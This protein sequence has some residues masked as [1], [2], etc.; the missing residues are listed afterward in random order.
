MVESDEGRKMSRR[1]RKWTAAVIQSRIAEGRGQREG[2]HYIPWHLIQDFPSIGRVHRIRG[3]K[4]DR[5]HHLFSDLELNAFFVF[6]L[7]QLILD[8][9][10][11]FPLFDIEETLEIA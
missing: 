11:Q 5:I 8:I 2:G 4:T 9:R 1:R 10:E 3:L 6:D 7:T